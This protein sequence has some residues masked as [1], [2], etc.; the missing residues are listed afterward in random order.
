M[1]DA[2]PGPAAQSRVGDVGRNMLLSSLANLVVPAVGLITAPLLAHALGVDGR[3]QLAAIMA[4]FLLLSTIAMFGLPE[5]VTHFVAK[6]PQVG[7][8]AFKRAL[9]M[10]YVVASL[11]GTC[12][13]V[14]TFVFFDVSGEYR[15]IILATFIALV[16][17]LCLSVVRSYAAGMH[18]WF[19]VN[20]E[21]YVS[22]F[23][24]VALLSC[25]AALGLLSVQA[26]AFIMLMSPLVAGVVY[27]SLVR[28]KNLRIPR[29]RGGPVADVT[30]RRLTSFGARIWVGSLSGIVLSR[31]DQVLMIP[32]SDAEQ[33]G[34]YAAAVSLSEVVLIFNTAVRDVLFSA[35]SAEMSRG[36]LYRASTASLL[37][38]TAI[39]VPFISTVWWWFPILFGEEFRS[40]V[41]TV[42][43]LIVAATIGVP[44]S[45]GGAG[46]SAWGRPGL[47]SVSLVI[48]AV[49]NVA[50]LLLLTP[51]LGALGAAM[52][53]LAGNFIASNLNI[54]FLKFK[55][56]CSFWQFYS[57]DLDDVRR[58]ASVLRRVVLRR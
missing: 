21:K 42:V 48:S 54:M 24:R 35:E 30:Y 2:H 7:N 57:V 28:R 29:L 5:A 1:S 50:L 55:F 49:I 25:F 31:V 27:V 16:P 46:L 36:R 26:A 10:V 40:G 12:G 44:G 22:A 41:P 15:I 34:L 23:A 39:S 17:T 3:G 14:I 37:A 20:V 19:I 6:Y 8:G 56:G 52:A 51:S 18:D 9:F 11:V 33:L 4:P 47:R 13:I 43:V 45:V 58:L 38:S 32:L 53:T